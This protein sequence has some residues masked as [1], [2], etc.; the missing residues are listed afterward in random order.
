M[1]RAQLRDAVHSSKFFFRK[2]VFPPA[3]SRASTASSSGN[4]TPIDG[5]NGI[6]GHAHANGNGTVKKERHLRNCFPPIPPPEEGL[7]NGRVETEYEEMTMN[8]IMNGKVCTFIAIVLANPFA[9][10]RLVLI[11][12]YRLFLVLQGDSFPGL[13]PLVEE[14]LGTLD[15][16]EPER[17]KFASYLNLIR[18]RANGKNT[19][20]LVCS[21]RIDSLL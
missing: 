4:V 11:N 10:G 5:V 6:N 20:L 18:S 8:E 13:I 3:S 9:F 19:I 1:H 21:V 17:K 15:V 2:S 7:P 14:F 12:G 16:Q